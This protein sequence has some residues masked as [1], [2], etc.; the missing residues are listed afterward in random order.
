LSRP[1]DW[2]RSVKA[3]AHDG[4][5]SDTKTKQLEFW[6]QLKEFA[7]DKY[8]E[9]CLR[10]PRPQH[11]YDISIGRPDCHIALIAD[12]RENQVRCELYIPDCKE[13]FYSFRS[14]AAQ[15]EEELA[16]D[17]PLDWKELP[18]KK[19][20]RIC[21]VRDFTFADP[22]T[23]PEALR[24]LVETAIKFK[25]VFGKEWKSTEVGCAPNQLD[26]QSLQ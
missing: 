3:S 20:A 1:N 10:T 8:P 21:V 18:G 16:L 13:L 14:S 24:W 7:S 17:A 5:L 15:I 9:L 11:W 19:A 22:A 26:S 4:D 23:W 6:Q 25:K 2:K 12:S